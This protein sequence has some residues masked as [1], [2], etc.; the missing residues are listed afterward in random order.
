MV[1]RILEMESRG[2]W[3]KSFSGASDLDLEKL[4]LWR[5]VVRREVRKDGELRFSNQIVLPNVLGE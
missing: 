5:V 1:K 4:L 3:G 2:G